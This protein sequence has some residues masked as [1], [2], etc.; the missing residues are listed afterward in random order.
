MLQNT[1]HSYLF[2]IHYSFFFEPHV[3]EAFLARP[4]RF[5]LPFSGIGIRCVI[6]LRHGRM[7]FP[8]ILCFTAFIKPSSQKEYDE[9][10]HV[11]YAQ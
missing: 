4:K 9:V 3:S 2:F 1:S 6:Q 10:D 11:V 5:E 8:I 7:F